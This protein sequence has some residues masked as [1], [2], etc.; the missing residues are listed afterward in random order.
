MW[1]S[2]Q[3]PLYCVFFSLVP[4]N[5]VKQSNRFKLTSCVLLLSV[6]LRYRIL[7]EYSNNRLEI[8]R[9]NI[10]ISKITIRLSLIMCICVCVS[11]HRQVVRT[12]D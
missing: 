11:Q 8:N 9:P 2:L 5:E 10:R 7:K 3:Y 4:Y 1:A 12:L 6:I